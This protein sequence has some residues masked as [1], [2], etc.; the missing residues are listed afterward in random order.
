LTELQTMNS[1]SLKRERGASS[2]KIHLN[3]MQFKAIKTEKS[4][5]EVTTLSRTRK[6][7]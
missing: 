3:A 5:L 7:S 1:N 4:V 2:D 6:V